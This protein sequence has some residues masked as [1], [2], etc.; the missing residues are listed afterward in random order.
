MNRKLR[1]KNIKKRKT[2]NDNQPQY[3]R[4]ITLKE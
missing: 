1:Q 3:T 4:N 2:G